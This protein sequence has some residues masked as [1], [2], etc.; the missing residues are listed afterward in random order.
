[1]V[2]LNM[3]CQ[4]RAVM[5]PRASGDSAEKSLCLYGPR[6]PRTGGFRQE[7]G[8]VASVSDEPAVPPRARRFVAS[9]CQI[10]R[11]SR[12]CSM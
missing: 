2:R 1:M 9:H 7:K 10:L 12:L 11:M 4:E 3:P 5:L 8:G 6:G